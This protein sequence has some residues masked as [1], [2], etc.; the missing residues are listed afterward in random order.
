MFTYQLDEKIYLKMLDLR[1]SEHLFDL[2]IGS[3]ESLREWLPFID[4]TKTVADSHSF[5]QSTMKQ[6]S[7]NNGVQA[8][9]WYDG[10]LAGVLGFHQINWNNKST[11]IGYWLG[12]DYVGLGLMTKAV[13]AFVHYALNDLNLNRVEIRAAVENKKSRAIPERLGFTEE[14]CI[15]QAEWLYDHYVDHVVYGMLKNDWKEEI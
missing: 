3:K 7:D 12:N 13:K 9:I 4:Y 14:G 6:F 2:T 15:R 1:D 11:S 10:K 5:I 8:G